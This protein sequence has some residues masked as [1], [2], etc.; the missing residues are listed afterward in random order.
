[1][2]LIIGVSRRQSV[3]SSP[4]LRKNLSFEPIFDPCKI[5]LNNTFK[6]RV[7]LNIGRKKVEHNIDEDDSRI[8]DKVTVEYRTGNTTEIVQERAKYW[9]TRTPEYWES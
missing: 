6:T 8:W 1:M 2:K 5:L 9:K 7:R 3:F 4:H